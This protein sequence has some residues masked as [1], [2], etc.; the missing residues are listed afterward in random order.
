M[1][2]TSGNQ[3]D[4][5]VRV[6][7]SD[8]ITRG[9]AGDLVARLVAELSHAPTGHGTLAARTLE[10]AAG[11]CPQAHHHRSVES[12]ISVTSGQATIRWGEN[13]EC[14]CTAGP[15]DLVIIPAGVPH[16][17]QNASST[18]VLQCVLLTV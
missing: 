11:A 4:H 17:A 3:R 2:D 12:V 16:Q 10:I 14:C 13:M 6:I 5:G 7:R 1:P 9:A 18:E 15:G 8:E